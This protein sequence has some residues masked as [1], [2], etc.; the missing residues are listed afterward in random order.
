M[1]RVRERG[2]TTVLSVPLFHVT[3]TLRE[4]LDRYIFVVLQQMS[5]R[6]RPRK[7]DERVGIGRDPSD[8]TDHVSESRRSATMGVRGDHLSEEWEERTS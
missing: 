6:H 7:V 1:K 5:L 2:H 4:Q 8:T 3:K